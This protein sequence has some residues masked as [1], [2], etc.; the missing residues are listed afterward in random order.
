MSSA[1]QGAKEKTRVFLLLLS[2]F[3]VA[4]IVYGIAASQMNSTRSRLLD[5]AIYISM[6]RTF[7][8]DGNFM[9]GGVPIGY[10][11]IL[12]SMIIS[13]AYFFYSPESILTTMRLIGVVIMCS[14][15]FPAYFLAER[16]LG[17]RRKSVI[18]A[19]LS[20]LIP[21][22]TLSYYM[23]QEILFYPL[24]LWFLNYF[25]KTAGSGLLRCSAVIGA[26]IY[27]L[28]NTKTIAIYVLV[29]YL[30]YLVVEC[31]LFNRDFRR[32]LIRALVVCTVFAALFVF[33]RVCIRAMN[34][35]A[36]GSSHYDAQILESVM[37]LFSDPGYYLPQVL[38][39]IALYVYY[40]MLSVLAFPFLLA[41]YGY[42]T[43]ND[44]DKRLVLFVLLC[45]AC[46]IALIVGGIFLLED[47][48]ST[49]PRFHSRYYF[50][51][52][53]P[54]FVYCMKISPGVLKYSPAVYAVLAALLLFPFIV[55]DG[56]VFFSSYVDN[57]LFA[58]LRGVHEALGKANAI[59]FLAV[60]FA[61]YGVFV[62]AL[63]FFARRS[64]V[65][66]NSL[67]VALLAFFVIL[68]VM[69]NVVVLGYTSSNEMEQRIDEDAL[70]LGRFVVANDGASAFIDQ[71]YGYLR[72]INYNTRLNEDY[73]Y[74][75][76][77]YAVEGALAVDG[78]VAF[79]IV[80]HELD[81]SVGNAERID[82]G[83]HTASLYRLTEPG[84]VILLNP[85]LE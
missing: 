56:F 8:Y 60:L 3:L 17:D 57:Y 59:V 76:A 31:A 26:L 42:K 14:A 19:G 15:V 4:V 30:F 83:L 65:R 11:C 75:K 74:Y 53:I 43:L 22:M 62:L 84:S 64:I 32:M 71:D 78:R 54:L 47:S 63:P 81:L 10:D 72:V 67:V 29:A 33:V 82:L 16:I 7:F 44:T 41:A 50:A 69:N 18:I 2:F 23:Y 21:S 70:A 55:R 49:T 58:V 37:A 46:A 6:A 66:S 5:E 13:V 34:G 40:T 36:A 39:G 77:S 28:Y 35:F 1:R 12:Y 85:V 52:F 79:V 24:V 38:R 51:F 61:A 73:F 27:L 9:R 68:N 80:P 20:L 25:Y 48:H 45:I